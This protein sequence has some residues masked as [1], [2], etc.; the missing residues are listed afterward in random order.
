MLITER[1]SMFPICLLNLTLR[2]QCYNNADTHV[3]STIPRM[4]KKCKEG[5]RKYNREELKWRPNTTKRMGKPR[6][7]KFFLFR[8]AI[9]MVK[10]WPWFSN[11]STLTT[12]LD[13]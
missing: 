8:K 2:A 3:T 6:G 10:I 13:S 1:G 4:E 7:D 5:V 12:K 11:F 9:F